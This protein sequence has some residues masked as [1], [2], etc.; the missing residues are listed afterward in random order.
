MS[1]RLQQPDSR[2]EEQK[3]LA[4]D[5]YLASDPALLAKRN[6]ALR[7]CKKFN[8]SDPEDAAGL[9][10]ILDQLCGGIGKDVVILPPVRMDYG[11]NTYIGER[12]FMNFG[13][14]ILD[15]CRVTI[16]N[17]VLFGPNVSL[18]SA[19]HPVDPAVRRNWGPELGKP[20]V[21]VG[22]GSVVTKDVEAYTVVAGNPARVI[23]RLPRPDGE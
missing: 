17:D 15:T 8:D 13:A 2:T 14:V 21:T 19:T 16:G 5:L 20:G 1:S 11:C 9:K 10:A 12:V 22:A 18:L 3:M 6:T 4:G 7:L 23:K